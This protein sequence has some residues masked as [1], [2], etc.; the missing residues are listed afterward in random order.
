LVT[1]IGARH[2]SAPIIGNHDVC[3]YCHLYKNLV[4]AD[5]DIGN[6]NQHRD[7]NIEIGAG[8]TD[9][10]GTQLGF[11]DNGA[12]VGCDNCH[13]YNDGVGATFHEFTEVSSA[14]PWTGRDL[15]GTGP[16]CDCD[17][18]HTANPANHGGPG[19]ESLTVHTTHT[20]SLP[21][22]CTD[23]HSNPGAGGHDPAHGGRRR[24]EVDRAGERRAGQFPR[25]LHE[26]L[27]RHDGD[28]LGR[29][30]P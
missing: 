18:R 12:T 16:D 30:A 19:G 27:A 4:T 23:C 9:G 26:H 21:V 17:T 15:I 22:I 6:V 10:S 28:R 20:S 7:G 14:A 1:G 13:E 5:Y 25:H 11:W 29:P 24:H 8:A 2:A 3:Y